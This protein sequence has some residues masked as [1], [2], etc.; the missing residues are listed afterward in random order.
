M[1]KFGSP[2]DAIAWLVFKIKKA[3]SKQASAPIGYIPF[4]LLALPYITFLVNT[5]VHI[6]MVASNMF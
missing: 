4:R 5:N 2:L 6:A 1:N 3:V